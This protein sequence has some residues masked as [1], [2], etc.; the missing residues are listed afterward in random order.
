MT[1]HRERLRAPISWWIGVA[2]FALTWGW[3]VLVAV[4]RPAA[5]VTA[6]VVAVLTGAAVWRYGSLTVAVDAEG[7]RA[8]RA[9]LDAPWV[10]AIEVLDHAAYRRRLGPGADVRALIVTR[11]WLDRGVLLH[12]DDPRDPTPY[13]LIGSRDPAALAASIDAVRQTGRTPTSRT[14]QE[15]GT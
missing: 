9:R 7:V 8:G 4:T 13:W 15:R 14:P 3:I 1:R 12:V 11:P 5:V 2:V 10:G 6:L